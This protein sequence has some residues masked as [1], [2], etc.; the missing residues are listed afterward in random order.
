MEL[1]LEDPLKTLSYE[2]NRKEYEKVKTV[3]M[4]IHLELA[5]SEYQEGD[6]RL[7]RVPSRN[8]VDPTLGICRIG[9]LRSEWLECLTTFHEPG[10]MAT[11]D[12]RNS[13]CSNDENS[14]ALWEEA[15]SHAW[16][17]QDSYGFLDPGLSP[18]VNYSIWFRSVSLLDD[19]EKKTP[20]RSTS[21][22]LCPGTEIKLAKP[23]L[24]RRL[25]IKL[26]MNNVRLQ[27]LAGALNW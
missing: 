11:V 20:Q 10:F 7:L 27:D 6:P 23:V 12:P 25:R 19:L 3:P 15:I 9:P 22:V 18:I 8:F 14:E 26:D 5:L 4:N 1:W 24:K 17:S 16:K 21:A 2:V 13:P